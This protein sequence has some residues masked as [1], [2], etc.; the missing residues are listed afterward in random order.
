MYELFGTIGF[1]VDF[2]GKILVSYTAISVHH[3]VWKE[4]KIDE[5]V[6]SIMKRERNLGILGIF[7]MVFGFTLEIFERFY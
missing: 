6:F 3:R 7:L 1:T 4:H 5:K 2:I